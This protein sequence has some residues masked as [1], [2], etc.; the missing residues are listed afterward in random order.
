MSFELTDPLPEDFVS[1][2][3][4]AVPNS[5]RIV[6]ACDLVP[7]LPPGT[8]FSFK[9]GGFTFAGGY[10]HVAANNEIA[11]LSQT[12]SIGGNHSSLL[13]AGYVAGM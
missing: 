10:A 6:N 1:N 9:V 12:G 8:K 5:Y 4:K 13:Y 11:F 2:Y 3:D 7:I